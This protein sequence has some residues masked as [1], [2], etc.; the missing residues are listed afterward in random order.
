MAQAFQ[1]T[2]VDRIFAKLHRELRGTTLHESD[3]IEWIGEALEFLQVRETQE[4]ALA[5]IE[6]KDYEAVVPT[7]MQMVLQMARNNNFEASGIPEVGEVVEEL[8]HESTDKVILDC[9][10]Q[11]IVDYEVAYYRPFFDLKYEYD[12]WCRSNLYYEQYTPIRLAN[13]TL[14][15]TL[16]CKEK[17]FEELYNPQQDEY[18]IVGTVDKK[19]RFS[20]QNGSIAVSYLRTA[21]GENGYPLVPDQISYIT[22]ITYYIKWK[23]AEWEQWNRRE[24]SAGLADKME[25]RW[26]KYARQS[27]NWAKMPKSIDQYQNLLEESHY[28]IPRLKRYYGFFGK[29][30]RAEDRLFNDP[31]YRR[32][33]EFYDDV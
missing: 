31:D 30:G 15:K 10:G 16:V 14:F 17:G 6:V 22:A 21:L 11:P 3:V 5:F 13:H 8:E 19:F 4:Q 2:S 26:L 20:F 32:K 25:Q 12:P 33:L 1:Y 7:G 29:L 27:K 24:G 23:I 18:T 28:L 9:N